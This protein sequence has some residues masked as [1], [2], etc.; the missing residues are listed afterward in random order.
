MK[1]S[2]FI[3]V[4]VCVAALSVGVYADQGTPAK[5]DSAAAQVASASAQKPALGKQTS[6]QRTT[7]KTNWSKIKTLF[8]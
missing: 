3:A 4:A 1:T 6:V 8:E 5:A 2:K 7:K